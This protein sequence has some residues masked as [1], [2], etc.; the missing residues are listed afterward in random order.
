MALRRGRNLSKRL[1][2]WECRC[3]CGTLT[4]VSAVHLVTGHTKSCGCLS[5]EMTAARSRTHGATVDRSAIPGE[6]NVWAG[7]R[8]RCFNLSDKNYGGRGITMCDQWRASFSAFLNDMGPRPSAEHSID[9]INVDG[10]YEPGNCRWATAMQQAQNSRSN[11]RVTI[12]DETMVLRAAARKFDVGYT[13]LYKAVVY[14]KDDPM[15]AI[16]RLRQKGCRFH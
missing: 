9:R 8:E 7:I 3:D 6:Y 11:I 4:T 10:N 1:T 14:R 5:S 12:N 13:A 2:A 16:K 15:T